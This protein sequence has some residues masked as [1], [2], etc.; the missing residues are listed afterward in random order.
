MVGR[1]GAVGL[2]LHPRRDCALAV[3]LV[4]RWAVSRGVAVFGVAGE[5][6]GVMGV[7]LL[8]QHRIAEKVDLLVS[9]GGDGTMLRALRLAYHHQIPVLGVNLG[10]FG[11]LAEIDPPDL[12]EALCSI[13]EERFEMESRVAVQAVVGDTVRIAFNDIALVRIPGRGQAA[14]GLVVSTPT[15]STA[16]S[17]SAGGPIVSPK[18][19]GLLVVP[20]APHSAFNRALMLACSEPLTLELLPSSG[21]LALEVDGELVRTVEPGER[22]KLLADV[23]AGSVIRLGAT[24]FYQR[25]QRKLRL[26]DAAELG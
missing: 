18:A 19:E 4:T 3:Q 11:F 15:G 13:A 8:E 20:V 26:S 17:F 14:V 24:T 9:L 12:D 1:V 7:Q 10:K 21:S 23:A 22:V 6:D 16:Y 5:L 2:V 25:A